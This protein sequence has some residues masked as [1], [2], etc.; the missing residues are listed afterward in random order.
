MAF[1]FQRRI[2]LAPGLR[3]N[4]SKRGLGLS[5]GPRGASLSMG[6]S[7]VHGH[8]GIPGTGLAYRQKLNA[9]NRRGS[10]PG[11][12]AGQPRPE[13]A[14]DALLAQGESLPIRLDI[15][16]DGNIDYFHG[17]GT[18]M[19]DDEARVLRRHARESLREQLAQHCE[20]LNADL[21][22]LGKLHEDTPHPHHNGYTTKGF[23]ESPPSPLELSPPV[24]WHFLWPPA[25]RQLAMENQRRQATF[26]EAYRSWEWRKAEHDAAEFARQQRESEGVMQDLDAMAQTLGERLEEIDWPRETAIDF[27]LGSVVST[28]A[29]DIDLPS[30][31][32]MPD[33]YWTMPAKQVKLT[34][35]K[36]S[37][38]RQRKLYRDHVHG[39][40][41]RVLGA[42]FARLPTVQEARVSGYRQI[43]DAATGGERDQYLYSV[44]VSRS[45]WEK[46]HFDKLDQ[47][48]PVAAM[49]A[50]ALRR[51][52][53]KTGVFR[54][55]EPFKLV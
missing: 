5:V 30:E 48:D 39:I 6:P 13:A 46:I 20:Q 2:T 27:D 18:P 36:L 55:I 52:M 9:R 17:D 7:G 50:F 21:D 11:S 26:E 32:E 38:T 47:V 35:R 14:M 23:T 15:D 31:D 22:R 29:V 40:A 16:S 4:L 34:P 10:R 8:A 42:V 1:R 45:Q 25:K 3:L 43:T 54:D 24:W 41:F 49:E 51:D 53:T 12:G 37:D 44:K 19:R 28:I 33:R